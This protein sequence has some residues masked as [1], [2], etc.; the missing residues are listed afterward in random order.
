MESTYY[1]IAKAGFVILTVLCLAF[2]LFGVRHTLLRVGWNARRSN[3][4]TLL[5]TAALLG[6][7]AFAS[8]LAL[9][10]VLS[11]FSATPPRLLLIILPPLIA[12]VWITFSPSFKAFLAHVPASWLISLQFFRVPVEIFLWLQFM[13]GLTPVQMTFEGRNWDVLTGL[14]APLIAWLCFR[15]GRN[16]KG[17]AVTWNFIGLALLLNIVVTAILS[18]PTPFRVF[19]NEPANTLVALFPIVF[20]PAVLV[21]LAYAL[22]L[23]SL[24]KAYLSSES[25]VTSEPIPAA[26]IQPTSPAV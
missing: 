14:S 12:I 23:F 15:G 25:N 10:G 21:P 3:K 5:V 11:N 26:A 16:L 9:Q 8:I 4:R 6:W 1:F 20:L 7:L 13:A 17:I 2:V 19:M 24:R 18:A 22:H